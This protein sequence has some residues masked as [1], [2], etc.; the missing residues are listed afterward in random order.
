MVQKESSL[1]TIGHSSADCHSVTK[2]RRLKDLQADRLANQNAAEAHLGYVKT[3]YLDQ[4]N[5]V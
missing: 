5:W 2:Q 1:P 4:P 3:L